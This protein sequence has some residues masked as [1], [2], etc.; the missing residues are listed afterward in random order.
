MRVDELELLDGAR[1]ADELRLIEDR[2]GMMR[3]G[4]MR[5]GLRR[6]Q[7]G[8]PGKA[9]GFPDHCPLHD[10]ENNQCYHEARP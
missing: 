1:H 8:N 3:K 2:E 4:L 5:E 10:V 9:E 6:Q 7:H